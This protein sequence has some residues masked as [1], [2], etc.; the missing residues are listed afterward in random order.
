MN[1]L[2][3]DQGTPP[4]RVRSI[5]STFARFQRGIL[6]L[7]GICAVSV[8][9]YRVLGYAWLEATWMVV[10]TIA[11]VGFGERSSEP[12][13]VQIWTILVIL[14]GITAAAYTFGGLLQIL[15]A[16]ELAQLLG[17]SRMRREIEK[18][19]DH[20]IIVGFGR[21]G[22][23]LAADLARKH[24]PF[25]VIEIDPD[26]CREADEL[27][28]LY[29]PGDATDDAVLSSAELIKART[30]VTALPNDANNVFITLTARN[31][32]SHLRIIARAE[33]LTSE[34]KLLQAGANRL[35]MPSTIGAQ[36]IGRMITRPH[37][38][39]LLELLAEHGNV[40][41]E[42]DEVELTPD[43]ALVGK[44]LRDSDVTK[45]FAV[46]VIAIRR[47]SG[48]L[49]V[50]AEGDYQFAPNDVLIVLAHPENLTR[51][52]KLQSA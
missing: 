2:L 14:F 12:P 34:R 50:A 3:G 33:H 11:S 48:E 29:I 22:R 39:D 28:Y 8:V 47:A 44:K 26:R 35:V 46:L 51:F 41:I 19:K 52:R 20:T 17:R 38:A 16:G 6:I 45:Q 7:A 15:L 4:W 27:K 32:S 42:I 36:Q 5:P 37:T 25:V 18:L 43:H 9:G 49:L 23:M 31:M 13:S 24:Q 40:R 21:I 1:V 30:L 10:I